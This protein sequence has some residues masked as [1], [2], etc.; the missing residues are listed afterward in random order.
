MGMRSMRSHFARVGAGQRLARRCA[1][2]VPVV[3]KKSFFATPYETA[4]NE[5]RGL[6]CCRCEKSAKPSRQKPPPQ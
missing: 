1:I 3:A 2:G 5:Q 6:P 4:Q